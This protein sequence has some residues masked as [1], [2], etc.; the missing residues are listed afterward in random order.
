MERGDGTVVLVPADRRNDSR[1]NAPYL[2]ARVRVEPMELAALE[3]V[4]LDPGMPATV[5]I[6]TENRTALQHLVS[7]LISAFTRAFRER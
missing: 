3:Y 1:T 2:L 4:Q 7:P 6:P 5:L